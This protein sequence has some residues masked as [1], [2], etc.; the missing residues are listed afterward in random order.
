MLSWS[1][2]LLYGC[3]VSAAFF[4]IIRTSAGSE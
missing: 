2:A 1:T 3:G 4:Q